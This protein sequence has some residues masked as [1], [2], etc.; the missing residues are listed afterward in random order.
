[1]GL[2]SLEWASPSSS[3]NLFG[4]GRAVRVDERNLNRF[5]VHLTG[6]PQEHTA[7]ILDAVA[8]RA[9][10]CITNRQEWLNLTEPT[11]TRHG[12]QIV[13]PGRFVDWEG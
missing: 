5:N 13:S 11:E 8:A 3:L 1:M 12:L 6:L 4:R 9:S 2:A 7:F 10:Y